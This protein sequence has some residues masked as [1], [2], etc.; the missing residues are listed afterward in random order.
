[1]RPRAF[2][3]VETLIALTLGLV[4]L[5]AL[6]ALLATGRQTHADNEHLA[7]ADEAARTALDLLASEARNA[8]HYGLAWPGTPIE[9]ATPAGQ[10][11]P[12]GLAV[13]GR[14]TASLALDL[15]VPVAAADGGYALDEAHALG[16]APGP[17]GRAVAGGDTLTLRR[18]ATRPSSAAAGRLQL[19]STPGGGRLLADG[20]R[21][22]GAGARLTDIEVGVFYVSADSSLGR[23]R[24]SLRRKRLVGGAAPAMQ[25]EELVPGIADLQVEFGLDRRDDGDRAVDAW[26]SAATVP[27]DADLRALRLWVLA[28]SDE[29]DGRPVSTTPLRY[30]NREFTPPNDRRRRVL[31]TTTVWLRNVA[32]QAP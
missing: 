15:A 31:A 12:A 29:P 17:L 16:C 8:G 1:M 14:C 24:P 3:L 22:G 20:R 30:A 6:I 18:V 2:A 32:E 10:P 27:G 11:E 23:G 21:E 26:S 28:E 13:G 5:A 4:L 9:G 19:E 7:R 25:D